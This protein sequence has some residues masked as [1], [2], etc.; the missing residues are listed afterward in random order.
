MFSLKYYSC[1]TTDSNKPGPTTLWKTI[2]G[3]DVKTNDGKDLGEIKT[4]Y[5]GTCR[6]YLPL[7]FSTLMVEGSDSNISVLTL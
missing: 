4:A 7:N 3:R 6:K 1:M 2:K 5:S